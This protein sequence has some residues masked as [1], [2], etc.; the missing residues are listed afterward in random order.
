M[1]LVSIIDK[2][3]ET[4]CTQQNKK[5]YLKCFPPFSVT[6]SKFTNNLPHIIIIIGIQPL[7][8]F[9]QRPELSQST[10]IALVRCILGK[11]LGGSLPLLSPATSYT[12]IKKIYILFS[13][14]IGPL[15]VKRLFLSMDHKHN[16]EKYTF[17]HAVMFTL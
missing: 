13:H 16:I 17:V 1:D 3:K 8:R 6:Q 2:N 4:Y 11:F 15:T 9:G 7:G 5:Y 14:V 12:Y 10:G